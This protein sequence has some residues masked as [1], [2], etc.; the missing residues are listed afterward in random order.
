MKITRKS[1]FKGLALGTISLPVAL[2]AILG[3]TNAQDERG[4]APGLI[5]GK[6]YQWK[7]VT[8]WPPN[9]PV[10]GEGC[11]MLAD[12]I[13]EMSGGRLDIQV[14]SGGELVPA[15][16]A[17]DAVRNGSAQMGS[18]SPYYWAGKAPAVQ[19]FS[20][21]PFGF[22]AQQQNAWLIAGG[23]MEL[24]RERY[25][26]FNLVPFIG[27]NTGVQMGG[28]FN[29]EIN[30]INDFRGL[31]MRIPGLGGRV[32]ERLGG[33]PV[34]LAG[35]EIYTGL[36]RGVIDATEWVGPYHDYVMGFH[37]IA[38][39]YYYPAWHEPGTAFEFFVNRQAY[40]A[41]PADLQAII[42]YAT[43]HINIWTLSTFEAKN[44]EYLEKIRQE[45][46]VDVRPFPRDVMQQARA[47]SQEVIEEFVETDA[48]TRRVYDSF[49]QFRRR[50]IEWSEITEKIY[51]DVIQPDN[52]M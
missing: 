16:E 32:L 20:S 27:G 24:W 15:L 10:L 42:R 45:P 22:N 41:L 8:T 11:I 6:R 7:M 1:F 36:E 23:G 17:F 35:G 50:S 12:I 44:A 31:K 51:Y 40:E 37:E 52:L 9:F 38:K 13:R 5:S 33:S 4:D 18:G 49:Q 47:V 19:F 25:A 46:T 34:L 48:F 26:D 30:T 43:D 14:F 39:Y 3:E 28:W 29:R 2:R 21:V